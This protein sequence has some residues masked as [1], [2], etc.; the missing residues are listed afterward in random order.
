MSSGIVSV[1]GAW[2]TSSDLECSRVSALFCDASR[3]LSGWHMLIRPL[4]GGGGGGRGGGREGEEVLLCACE[5]KL[6]AGTEYHLR[7]LCACVM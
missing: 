2:S 4:S 5:R 1:T 7:Y 6:T 3:S